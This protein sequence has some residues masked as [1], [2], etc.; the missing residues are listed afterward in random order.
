MNYPGTCITL[1][2]AV[3]LCL[4]VVIINR[5]EQEV[6]LTN[7][8]YSE[9][10]MLTNTKDVVLET[11]M[12]MS[13]GENKWDQTKKQLEELIKKLVTMRT[14]AKNVEL[15]LVQCNEVAKEA[16]EAIGKLE[17][18][19]SSVSKPFDNE[20]A[21]WSK[22]IASLKKEVG[23]R[24]KVCS[25]I[26]KTSDDAKKLC[27]IPIEVAAEPKKE[28]PKVGDTE[29][30]AA[31]EEPKVED[32]EKAAGEPKEEGPKVGDTEKAA[33]EEEP[34]VGDTEK[35]AAEPKEEGPKGKNKKKAAQKAPIRR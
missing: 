10:I 12:A 8:V 6:R 29:K 33:A 15:E 1:L 5:R 16:A 18:E 7:E 35:A 13:K 24:S 20:R 26:I 2:M 31:E 3:S 4:T 34:K 27:G 19:K 17:T 11:S 21:E 28:E 30:S 9:E 25:Y 32:T 14:A 23:Q 22:N